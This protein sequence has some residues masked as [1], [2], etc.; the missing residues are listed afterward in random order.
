MNI[1]A[2]SYQHN[3]MFIASD[4]YINYFRIFENGQIDEKF[5]YKA[6]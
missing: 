5:D 3:L 6:I 2:V 1:V 4:N